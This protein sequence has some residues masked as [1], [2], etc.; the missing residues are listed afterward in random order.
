MTIHSLPDRKKKNYNDVLHVPISKDIKE[1]VYRV[2]KD[3]NNKEVT[4][5]VRMLISEGLKSLKK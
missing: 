4:E 3:E 5:W 1:E 2:V